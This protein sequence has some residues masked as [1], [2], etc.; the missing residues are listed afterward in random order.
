MP[1]SWGLWIPRISLAQ[2]SYWQLIFLGLST[3]QTIGRQTWV[4][5]LLFQPHGKKTLV[6]MG[7]FPKQLWRVLNHHLQQYLWNCSLPVFLLSPSL[8]KLAGR[9]APHSTTWGSA[10]FYRGALRIP[11]KRP[12]GSCLLPE[13]VNAWV[14]HYDSA[15]SEAKHIPLFGFKKNWSCCF[16]SK[17]P[18]SARSGCPSP[19]WTRQLHA[20]VG[21]LTLGH[22]RFRIHEC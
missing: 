10:F 6:K 3:S 8:A 14:S 19:F 9:D 4:Y 13:Q 16:W 11:S 1:V 18:R 22:A 17:S 7:I 12:A 15:I 21:A 20:I 5:R 2:E